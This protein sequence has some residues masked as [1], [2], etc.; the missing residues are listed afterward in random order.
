MVHMKTRL[1]DLAWPWLRSKVGR[2][3]VNSQQWRQL[4]M[5]GFPALW[6]DP[7][8]SWPL[9]RGSIFLDPL[10][11]KRIFK[12]Q[13]SIIKCRI[14]FIM[15][16][17]RS[18][19]LISNLRREIKKF[20]DVRESLASLQENINSEI[21]SEIVIKSYPQNLRYKRYDGWY[22][23]RNSNLTNTDM[24]RTVRCR[25]CLHIYPINSPRIGNWS[26]YGHSDLVLSF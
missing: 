16:C 23:I 8:I 14:Q 13:T 2:G 4:F 1:S 5:S 26:R 6:P 17:K 19:S 9:K 10:L 7:G 21:V 22:R 24:G 25:S 11:R 15:I 18:L 12:S 3:E 20:F